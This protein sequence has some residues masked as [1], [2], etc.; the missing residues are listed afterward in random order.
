MRG[1]NIDGEPEDLEDFSVAIR[2]YDN[3]VKPMFFDKTPKWYEEAR[4]IP[5]PKYQFKGK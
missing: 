1:I 3:V 4:Q 2:F 5:K